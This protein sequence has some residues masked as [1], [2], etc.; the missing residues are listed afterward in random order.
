[1]PLDE[2][3]YTRENLRRKLQDMVGILDKAGAEY[4][5]SD[6]MPV[7]DMAFVLALSIGGIAEMRPY[8]LALKAHAEAV[9]RP[10]DEGD[11]A[12]IR[13]L[14]LIADTMEGKKREGTSDS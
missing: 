12:Q 14:T 10:G 13:L 9:A 2:V 3:V 5:P 7:G 6:T 4:D 1:M 8:V 11:E